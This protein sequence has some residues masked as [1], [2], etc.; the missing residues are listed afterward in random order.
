MG[1]EC[2]SRL[3]PQVELVTLACYRALD[4]TPA[5]CQRMAT[6]WWKWFTWCRTAA[7]RLTALA[8]LLALALPSAADLPAEW[9]E[10]LVA[11]GGHEAARPGGGGLQ[12]HLQRLLGPDAAGVA[13]S[14]AAL[15]EMRAVL[16]ADAEAYARMQT[17]QRICLHGSDGAR[18]CSAYSKQLDQGK[19]MLDA[20]RLVQIAAQEHRG[21]ILDRVMQSQ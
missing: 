16:H 2:H 12:P 4:L 3:L 18:L 15:C 7:A 11:V 13:A 21:A 17:Y 5:Q 19:L 1:K 10:R 8:A 6:V 14:A 9:L 20:F